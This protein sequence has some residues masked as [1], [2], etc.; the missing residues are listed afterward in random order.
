MHLVMDLVRRFRSPVFIPSVFGDPDDLLLGDSLRRT[1]RVEAG[2]LSIVLHASIVVVAVLLIRPGTAPIPVT[3]AKVILTNPFFLP[4]GEGPE[5]GGGGGGGKGEKE[6][7]IWGRMPDAAR[8]QLIPPDPTNLQPL[9]PL[10]EINQL[11][12]TV[13]L[14]IEIP[15]DPAFPIGD[16]TAPMT[17]S[18]SSGPGR[19]R[20]I[21]TGDG[22][23]VGPGKGPG[24]GPGE[25][26]GTGGGPEGTMGKGGNGIYGPGTA[27]LKYPVVLADPKPGYTE[28]ARRS[29]TEGIVLIQAVI[30]KD[31]SV[32]SFKVLRGL[33]HGLDESA[34]QT[35]ASRWRFRPGT[36]N[37]VPV[38][39][40][41]SIEVSFR[42]F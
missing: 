4:P 21:G 41:A 13:V 16:L 20:G 32:D 19:F 30:R 1:R 2:L 42:L 23:G 17:G 14:P 36:L 25:R 5:G 38:D 9:V 12:A 3:E 22:D 27:G 34:I 39:V 18:H 15:H 40:L 28:D 8:F 31:G 33:G 10:D 26:G 7:P 29:R 6:P 37:G 11:Q 35:I 24:Y